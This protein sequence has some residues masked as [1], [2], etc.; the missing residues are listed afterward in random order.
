MMSYSKGLMQR[1]LQKLDLAALK[2]VL[3]EDLK[4]NDVKPL[5]L[6]QMEE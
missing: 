5:F 3:D 4:W 2:K 1:L 6:D